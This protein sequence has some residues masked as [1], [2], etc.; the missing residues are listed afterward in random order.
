MSFTGEPTG[1]E[2]H[3]TG[4]LPAIEELD[5]AVDFT[6]M[7]GTFTLV[8]PHTTPDNDVLHNF[9]R[10]CASLTLEDGTVVNINVEEGSVGVDVT[11]DSP[12]FARRSA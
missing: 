4:E 5:D 9:I 12:R 7:G 1:E 11:Y 10:F 2:A 6:V 8:V 3:D